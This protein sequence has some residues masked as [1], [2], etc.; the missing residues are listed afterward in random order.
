[1]P[2]F[3]GRYPHF[4]GAA[5]EQ[6]PCLPD[7]R[8]VGLELIPRAATSTSLIPVTRFLK[9]EETAFL[10]QGG[11]RIHLKW[12]KQEDCQG[13]PVTLLKIKFFQSKAQV[14][15]TKRLRNGN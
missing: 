10:V 8:S 11:K 2:V 14:P 15:K 12:R 6:P 3:M 9:I 4:N 13:Q 5:P 7:F 1:M